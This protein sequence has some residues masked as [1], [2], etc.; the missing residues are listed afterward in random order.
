M[1]RTGESL[2]A[3]A[4]ADAR[5]GRSDSAHHAHDAELSRL[6]VHAAGVGVWAVD[7]AH[8]QV[9]WGG[10]YAELLGLAPFTGSNSFEDWLR[11][12]HEADRDR[13]EDE[14]RDAIASGAEYRVEYRY[15][16]PARGLRWLLAMGRRVDHLEEEMDRLTGITLDVTESKQSEQDLRERERQGRARTVE[17]EAVLDAVPAAVWIAHD[18]ECKRITGNRA[19]AELLRLPLDANSSLSAPMEERPANFQILSGGIVLTPSQLPM[20]RAAAEGLDIRGFE[21]VIHFD[22]GTKRQ[23]YGNSAPLF[24]DSGKVR[25][26]V[27][28]FI[29][30]SARIAAEEAL[31]A[32]DRRKDEFIA[33]LSHELRNPLA[34][35][36]SVVEVMRRT[37]EAALADSDGE[38]ARNL[39][40]RQ[41]RQLTRLID[42][43]LDISRI[44]RG[45]ISLRSERIDATMVIAH[46][47]ATVRSS[48]HKR[49]Q[50]LAIDPGDESLFLNADPARLEQVVVNLL[51]NAVRYTGPGGTIILTARREGENAVITVR[52]NG[53]GI[54]GVMIPKIFDM[55][56][57]VDA[58]PGQAHGGLG[59]GLTLVRALTKLHGGEI[60]AESDGL[61]QGSTFTL[62]FPLA[63][64]PAEEP[65]DVSDSVPPPTG[66]RE[67]DGYIL[68]VDDNVDAAEGLSRL[69]R[70]SGRE[71]LVVHDG[72]AA[73]LAAAA[74][75]PATVLLDIGLPGMDGHEVAR[76]L[77]GNLNLTDSLLIAIS[78]YSQEQD[79]AASASVGI[80]HH[81]VKPVVIAD[82]LALL[83]KR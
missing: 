79:R 9:D 34:A 24:D 54:A 4:L 49:K 6:A 21:E 12:V 15:R 71:V 50:T 61:G 7:L 27:A 33:I 59:I 3:Q 28:A 53:M 46:A 43:L 80:D 42:D 13:V 39:L 77:R 40:E 10:G 69:L 22:D 56:T 44:S 67:A 76:Q 19:A 65:A 62:R 29:D 70:L 1:L 75:K 74:R 57:Q 58:S 23:V 55:F 73:L 52:D 66:S 64:A 14:L 63:E 72:T 31:R 8:R 36:D 11:L 82:L 78:G 32:A 45:K 37:G 81:L 18:V 41:V 35:I 5:G 25:G 30:I 2:L 26:A 68:V 51:T 47:A 83:A 60:I 20:Q 16:H 38:W 17:L 48:A